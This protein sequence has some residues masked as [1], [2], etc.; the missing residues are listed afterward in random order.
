MTLI[1][2]MLATALQKK[3]VSNPPKMAA[4]SDR[5]DSFTETFEALHASTIESII[6]GITQNSPFVTMKIFLSK[7]EK[8]ES[9]LHLAITKTNSA[10]SAPASPP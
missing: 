10:S 7:F 5:S 4:L 1:Q 9:M 8:L 6:T 2:E 3:N